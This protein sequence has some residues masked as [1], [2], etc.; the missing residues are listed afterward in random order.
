MPLFFIPAIFAIDK[1]AYL[2][3]RLLGSGAAIASGRG[4]PSY[5]RSS[6]RTAWLGRCVLSLVIVT[7]TYSILSWLSPRMDT[8]PSLLGSWLALLLL[9]RPTP[10]LFLLVA[11]LFVMATSTSF[12]GSLWRRASER[13]QFISSL[14]GL[15]LVCWWGL[16]FAMLVWALAALRR[17]S[18]Q[19]RALVPVIPRPA[20][21]NSQPSPE[22]FDRLVAET[23]HT[24]V[25]A[26]VEWATRSTFA[27]VSVH[28]TAEKQVLS[29]QPSKKI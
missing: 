23:S 13:W 6:S 29:T 3:G 22:T 19:H 21:D 11:R 18:Q 26:S 28:V 16:A 7:G 27:R 9:P 12:F 20:I 5:S 17:R 1:M 24:Q 15:F 25:N 10:R 8:V 2:L 4:A 14:E